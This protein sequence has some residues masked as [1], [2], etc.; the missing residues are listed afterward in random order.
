MTVCIRCHRPLKAPTPTGMGRVCAG[1]ANSAPPPEHERDLFGY[2]TE[3]AAHAARCRIE[4][5]ILGLVA[6]AHIAVFKQASA[7]RRAHMERWIA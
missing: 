7:L 2:D 4:V 1:R 5:L 6:E 3:K